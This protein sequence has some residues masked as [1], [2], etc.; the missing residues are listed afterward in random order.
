MLKE[1]EH[2]KQLRNFY[3]ENSKNIDELLL[4]LCRSQDNTSRLQVVQKLTEMD[5]FSSQTFYTFTEVLNA[6]PE[7]NSLYYS[8]SQDEYR[9][10]FLM[11]DLLG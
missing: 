8:I 9:I 4:D 6:E 10:R 7:N 1:E 2:H 11:I 3:L 5:I